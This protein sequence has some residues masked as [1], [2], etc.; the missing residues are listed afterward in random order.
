MWMWSISHTQRVIFKVIDFI[1]IFYCCSFRWYE[2][3]HVQQYY[4]VLDSEKGVKNEW[5]NL[6]T[7]A[8]NIFLLC[9]ISVI[10]IGRSD[11]WNDTTDWVVFHPSRHSASC[12]TKD[13]RI[14]ANASRQMYKYINHSETS[15][16][17]FIQKSNIRCTAL[18]CGRQRSRFWLF[19][20]FSKKK[21][22][23]WIK[24]I[25]STNP[26]SPSS[27]MPEILCEFECELNH[28]NVSDPHVFRIRFD[29]VFQ[30]LLWPFFRLS[31]Q[32]ETVATAI[33]NICQNVYWMPTAHFLVRGGHSLLNLNI[34][35]H[36]FDYP[37]VAAVTV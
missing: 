34:L 8:K 2:R 9:F 19:W 23:E 12:L 30:S 37:P 35:S 13:F 21:R 17:E 33:A 18:A 7:N 15:Q 36:A 22:I 10:P 28:F 4:A 6:E 11:V 14:C 3:Q 32:R 31:W 1:G 16:P 27:A 24:K 25:P 20:A 5:S 26:N 29:F